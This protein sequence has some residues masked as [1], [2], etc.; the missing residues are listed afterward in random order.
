MNSKFKTITGYFRV[1]CVVVATMGMMTIPSVSH[2]VD[3]YGG[4][5]VGEARHEATVGDLL[6]SSFTTGSVDGNDNGWKAFA[7]MALWDKYVGAEFGY[8]DL[9]EATAKSGTASATSRDKGY[10]AALAGLIPFTDRFGLLLKFGL[11]GSNVEVSKSVSGVST[12]SHATDL[13]PFGGMGFQY[14]FS[15]N[16]GARVEVERYNAGS[17][18]SPYINLI[19]GGIV[20]RFGK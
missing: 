12:T 7:G 3:W 6:G 9:G 8:V 15:K 20:F 13:N 16:L 2:A 19:S 5:S 14:D 18:G 4:L 17:L 11:I 1:V 10:T